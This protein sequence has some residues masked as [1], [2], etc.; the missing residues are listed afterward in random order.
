MC[1]LIHYK[2]FMQ[3]VPLEKHEQYA[4]VSW[5]DT[6]W[7][8]YTSIPNSTYTKSWNQKKQNKM[9]GLRKWFPDMVVYLNSD[10]SIIWEPIILFVELKRVSWWS[11]SKE[12]KEWIS[13]LSSVRNCEWRVCKWAQEAIDFVLNY[14]KSR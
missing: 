3:S 8:K 14:T 4:F 12:Q 2:Y 9:M 1:L 10:Q 13:C 6:L 7:Y 5:L 11:T